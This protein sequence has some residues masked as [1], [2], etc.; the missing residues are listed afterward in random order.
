MN[1]IRQLQKEV[2]VTGREVWGDANQD[3]KHE[4]ILRFGEEALELM[5][6]GG[7]RHSEICALLAYEFSREVGELSQEIAGVQNTLFGVATANGVDV[8]DAVQKEIQRVLARKDE[9][10]AKHDAKPSRLKH[11]VVT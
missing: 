11:A 4:R 10:R 6:A 8:Y 3:S 1:Q 2:D 7:L 9:C 5:R